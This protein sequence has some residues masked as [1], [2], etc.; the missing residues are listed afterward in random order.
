MAFS[1]ERSLTDATLMTHS[2][3]N[4]SG[5]NELSRTLH[6]MMK[7]LILVPAWFPNY[8]PSCQGPVLLSMNSIKHTYEHIN[9]QET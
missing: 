2:I 4:E 8:D 6:V 9:I 3:T 5:N 1:G 7:I